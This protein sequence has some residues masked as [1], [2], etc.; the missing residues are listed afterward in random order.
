[1]KYNKNGNAFTAALISAEIKESMSASTQSASIGPWPTWL[2]IDLD[3]LPVWASSSAP[4]HVSGSADNY[5]YSA[6]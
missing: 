1:M 4:P 3:M 6:V 5:Y 2:K